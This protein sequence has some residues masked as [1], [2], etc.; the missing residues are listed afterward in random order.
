MEQKTCSYKAWYILGCENCRNPFRRGTAN[1][2]HR[3]NWVLRTLI[4][5]TDEHRHCNTPSCS[6]LQRSG[7][8]SLL[9]HGWGF[10]RTCAPVCLTPCSTQIYLLTANAILSHR[11][12]WLCGLRCVS[13]WSA[14]TLGSWARILFEAFFCVVLSCVGRGFA[15][16]RSPF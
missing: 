14:R 1:P 2:A 10:P 3:V 4:S 8:L 7:G 12:H 16:G 15:I 6:L 5:R 9:T 13:F 11:F